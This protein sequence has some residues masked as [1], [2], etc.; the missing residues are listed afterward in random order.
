M[1]WVV[2]AAASVGVEAEA[3]VDVASAGDRCVVVIFSDLGRSM[4][5]ESEAGLDGFAGGWTEGGGYG[6]RPTVS[7]GVAMAE[8]RRLTRF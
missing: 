8:A 7:R 2:S 3:K 6:T 5:V 4:R 1:M